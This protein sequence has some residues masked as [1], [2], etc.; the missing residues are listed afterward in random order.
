MNIER[1]RAIP[2]EEL[3]EFALEMSDKYKI[4]F[5]DLSVTIDGE[6]SWRSDVHGDSGRAYGPSQFHSETFYSFKELAIEQGFPFDD[7]EYKNAYHQIELMAWAFTQ[8]S[9]P[10]HWTC[11]RA[12]ISGTLP[13]ERCP[14]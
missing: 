5:H 1:S 13:I 10:E 7:F 3:R 9:L 11:Y 4:S 12:R 6:S 8:D 14:W 2:I